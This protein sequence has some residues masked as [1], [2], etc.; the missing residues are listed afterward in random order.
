MLQVLKVVG[1]LNHD[2]IGY[3][4]SYSSYSDLLFHLRQYKE[5]RYAKI[6]EKSLGSLK[7]VA[8]TVLIYK[9]Q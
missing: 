3:T 4:Y 5:G 9:D 6:E 2:H 8:I 7:H 1:H